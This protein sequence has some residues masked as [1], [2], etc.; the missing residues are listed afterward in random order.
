[1]NRPP[2]EGFSL[3]DLCRLA[4]ERAVYMHIGVARPDV[5][6]TPPEITIQF[7]K[8]TKEQ[9]IAFS[10]MLDRSNPRL[11]LGMS[12]QLLRKLDEFA[13]RRSKLIVL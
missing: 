4:H 10:F 2:P 1:M 13:P 3:L 6:K 12:M 5:G 7:S 8:A 9:P 11:N